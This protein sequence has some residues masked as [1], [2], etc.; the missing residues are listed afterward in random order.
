MRWLAVLAVCV[1]C[2][3]SGP[4]PEKP[5]E[6]VRY[7]DPSWRMLGTVDHVAFSRDESAIYVVAQDGAVVAF[8]ARTGARTTLVDA[9]G[10][11]TS[12]QSVGSIDDHTLAVIGNSALA[13]DVLTRQLRPL[14]VP[15]RTRQLAI[16][17]NRAVV[18]DR[19]SV[20]QL[21]DLATGRVVRDFERSRGYWDPEIVGDRVIAGRS[22]QTLG[23]WNLS[24]GAREAVFALGNG[25]V[26]ALS[27]DHQHLAVGSFHAAG[28]WQVDL[29]E[30]G[31][32]EVARFEFKSCNPQ[33]VAFSPDGKQLAI[34]CEDEIR[35]VAV[36]SGTVLKQLAGTRSYLRTLAWS[37]RGK[38]L[39]AGG[40][41]S[42]LHLWDTT[43]WQPR[44]R[45][46]GPRGEIYRL[47]G[48]P[49][50]LVTVSLAANS[51]WSWD[52]RSGRPLTNFGPAT[53]A[54][55]LD[56]SDVLASLADPPRIERRSR[57]GAPLARREVEDG[58][59]REVGPVLG[60]GAWQVRDGI[61]T[62]FDDKLVPLWHT[63]RQDELVNANGAASPDGRRI[64]LYGTGKLVIVDGTARKLVTSRPMPACLGEELAV[65]PDARRLAA[66]DE[67]GI[68]LLDATTGAPLASFALPTEPYDASRTITF[69]APDRVLAL[70]RSELVAWTID[71]P[72]ATVVPLPQVVR[73]AIHDDLLYL[74][75]RDG[76]LERRSL[77][78]LLATGKPR[79]VAPAAACPESDEGAGHGGMIGASD[80]V[81]GQLD[82][83]EDH[84]D[85][86]A[87]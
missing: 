17:G 47:A 6:V 30:L 14:L 77:A 43:T 5:P 59:V 81:R 44:T 25:K 27:S 71:A 85:A 12:V 36:P 31:G 67:T 54:L 73:L 46:V 41:D 69:A 57:T 28:A 1:A 34:G 3:R 18:T 60:H 37:P 49:R 83:S 11:G 24:T 2:E 33:R 72:T 38:L 87:P 13:F 35:I 20:L 53:R 75:F 15:S 56:G 79:S 42:V 50:T 32:R 10:S 76:T 40:N 9:I 80:D 26:S 52:A 70:V 19:Q 68:R 86:E 7:G 74:A 23:V 84:Q 16:R 45:L 51:A 78:K 63:E 4:P 55:A 64:A 22:Y 8:D 29:Y 48:D 65:A 21:V 62:I 39:V 58:I 66:I 82:N 61:I